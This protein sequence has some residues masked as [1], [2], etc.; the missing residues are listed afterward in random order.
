MKSLYQVTLFKSGMISETQLNQLIEYS[1]G[2]A[3]GGHNGIVGSAQ[4]TFRIS[5]HAHVSGHQ[6]L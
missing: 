2:G 5:H 4:F 1:T 3:G 6:A